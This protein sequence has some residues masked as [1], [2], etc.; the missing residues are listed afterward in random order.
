MNRLDGG[1]RFDSVSISA[2]AL[3]VQSIPDGTIHAIENVDNAEHSKNISACARS[4]GYL[5]GRTAQVACR[6][7]PARLFPDVARCEVTRLQ[8]VQD[9]RR[10]S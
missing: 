10:C 2:K 8:S 7:V 6:G 4:A 5:G 3:Y 9:G 1:R